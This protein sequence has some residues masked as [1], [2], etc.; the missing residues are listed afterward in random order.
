MRFTWEE[1]T[2]MKRIFVTVGSQKFQFNRLLKAVDDYCRDNQCGAEVFAQIGYSDYVP[3]NYGYTKFLDRD[4]FRAETAKADLIITHGGTG[5]ILG[6]LKAGKK[7]IVVP[8][9]ARYGEHVDDHQL[10]LLEKF[11][12]GN[13][14]CACRDMDLKK[15]VETV[16][17]TEYNAYQS[18]TQGILDSIEEFIKANIF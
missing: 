9:L 8:R 11:E 4:E 14:I 1:Y 17:T 3:Q 16:I 18:N 5:A 13:L 2:D 12:K 6:A 7:V 15:A 10:Q